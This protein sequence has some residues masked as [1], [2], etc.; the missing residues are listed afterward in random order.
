MRMRP[1]PRSRR[2]PITCA[3]AT[4][5]TIMMIAT[6]ITTTTIRTDI[7]ERHVRQL[8]HCRLERGEPAQDRPRQH[9]DLRRRSR[10]GRTAGR[11]YAD[12]AQR[13]KSPP[14]IAVGGERG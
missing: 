3:A 7:A 6:M 13:G 9:L 8:C 12:A 1:G 14:R 10:W 2:I 5:G 11:K 4:T